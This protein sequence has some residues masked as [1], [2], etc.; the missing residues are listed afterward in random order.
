[1]LRFLGVRTCTLPAVYRQPIN[2]LAAHMT[3]H[4]RTPLS[5]VTNNV[6]CLSPTAR[7]PHT[8]LYAV[9]PGS[10]FDDDGDC[11]SKQPHTQVHTPIGTADLNST[12]VHNLELHVGAIELIVGPMFAGKTTRLLQRVAQAEAQGH[13][14]L[15]VKSCKD[16]R[17]SHAEVVSHTGQRRVC[18]GGVCKVSWLASPAICT[19]HA[20]SHSN[21]TPTTM[22]M[23]GTQACLAVA[24]LRDLQHTEEFAVADVVA[25]DEAQFLSDAAWFAQWAADR[26]CKRVI[27]AG[28]D[29]DYKRRKFGQVRVLVGGRHVGYSCCGTWMLWDIWDM[30]ASNIKIKCA[31]AKPPW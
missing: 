24:Q 14:V 29:G 20:S 13:R 28:L 9:A 2:L 18:G 15:L 6:L 3:A 5:V 26:H 22:G 30:V 10:I 25:V 31:P 16:D 7:Q 17:Y 27:M 23:F 12:D 21:R 1:M 8:K 19:S 4:Q 11:P